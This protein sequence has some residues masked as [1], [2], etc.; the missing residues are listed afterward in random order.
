MKNRIDQ[1][2]LEAGD[3]KRHDRAEDAHVDKGRPGRCGGENQQ[4]SQDEPV[5]FG[6]DDVMF[7][8]S[9][10]R[11]WLLSFISYFKGWRLMRYSSGKRKIQTIS[12]K[13][14]YSPKLSIVEVC[15]LTYA[16]CQAW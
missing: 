2:S 10:S 15:P 3:P 5:G 11:T 8:F 7:V 13:C 14:Q 6:T 4:G 16:P 9:R 1:H 12:T